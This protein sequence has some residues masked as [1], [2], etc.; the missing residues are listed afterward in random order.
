MAARNIHDRLRK[1][2]AGRGSYDVIV[3]KFQEF[4]RRRGDKNYYIRGTY[5]HN[6]VEFTKD[7]FHMADLGFT[8]LSMEPV[9]SKPDDPVH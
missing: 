9:V 4:V 8:E 3:P 6:N 5:T 1:D 7:V 2:Y